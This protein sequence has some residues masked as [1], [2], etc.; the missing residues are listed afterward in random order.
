MNPA[1]D[2]QV[3]PDALA[4]GGPGAVQFGGFVGQKMDQCIRNRVMAQDVEKLILPFRDRAEKDGSGWRCEYWGKWFA[5]AALAYA[6]QPTQAHRDVLD[7]ALRDLMATQTPDG[8]IGTYDEQHHLGIWDVWGRKYV[9][10]G[11]L[12]G[13]DQTGEQAVLEAACR[14]ADHLIAEAPPGKV[15]LADTGIDVLKGLAP[16][17]ILE[18]MVLLDRRT[19][20]RKYMDFAR[21][22]VAQW[23]EP[24]C[25]TSTGLR[26][27]EEALAGT[28]PV[29]IGSP[30]AYEMMSCFEGLCELYRATGEPRLLEAVTRFAKSIRS[31]E[32]MI[33]GS[34]SNQEL[35]CDGARTQSEILEQPLE[36]C[37]TV[38]WMKL[39]CRLL[40]LTGEPVWADELETSLFN[41]LLAAMTP[42]GDW[43]TYY[44]P[45]VGERVP[46]HSQHA[47]V[48]LSCCVANGPRGL[49]LTPRW[50][51]M[52]ATDG[53]VVNLYAPLTA[54]MPL[55]DGTRVRITQATD[56]PQTDE[57][58]LVIEPPQPRRFTLRLRIP[59]WSRQT[60]LSA[61]G[62]SVPC[63]S[64]T[65]A[66]ID[67]TWS[68]SDRVTLKLDLRG[69]A[70][71]APSGAPQLALMRGPVVLALDN[72]LVEP[73]DVSVRLVV[74]AEGYVALAPATGKPQEVW[75]AFDVP[76]EVRPSHF[77]NHRQIRLAM[78]DYA[79][80]GN[81]QSEDNLY[82]V[83]LPQPLFLREAFPTRT[84]KLIYPDA[85]IRPVKP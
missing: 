41:A 7:K 79:S 31:T 27:V 10:L 29:R 9:L 33:V 68:P 61:N 15:N 5:S 30:K 14:A 16:S 26:L 18:P 35:W 70:I 65:Y 52:S 34:C 28:P 45:L 71:P 2:T 47:D 50:A 75:M 23:T 56:Y 8:Y 82:R 11:L 73:Q 21:N 84:W 58:S 49:L 55:S 22:I 72:R 74:D 13:Y 46:S 63:Q 37:V 24:T 36:T 4:P 62:E 38:T 64:G 77:F 81:R 60:A 19:G 83:W 48:G 57:V 25:F 59:A 40:E 43:W 6:Y 32:R 42:A 51:V 76:F 3:A 54:E 67:R 17:S 85:K 80:A 12:A 78:C 44:T 53:L 39:C 20:L 69:R 66:R 1:R